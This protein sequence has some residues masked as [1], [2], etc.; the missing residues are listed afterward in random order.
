M[1]KVAWHD[2]AWLHDAHAHNHACAY[3]CESRQS[4]NEYDSACVSC[5]DGNDDD[6]CAHASHGSEQDLQRMQS[7]V[8][9]VVKEISF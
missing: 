4:C 1:T 5:D 6:A 7:S 8:L 2:N 3:E 9:Q